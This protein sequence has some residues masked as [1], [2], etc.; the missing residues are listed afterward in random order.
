MLRP[1][2]ALTA[3]VLLAAALGCRETK[4]QPEPPHPARVHAPDP[5]DP[6]LSD[7]LL[8]HVLR[9]ADEKLAGRPTWGPEAHLAR[10]YIQ[11]Q[12]AQAGFAPTERL[13]PRAGKQVVLQR[14]EVPIERLAAGNFLRIKF[15]EDRAT[16]IHIGKLGQTFLP[17]NL[18]VTAQIESSV[19]FAG[20]GVRA[21]EVQIDDYREQPV[22]RKVVFVLD[23]LPA[24]LR[25][26]R[27]AATAGPL[28][29]GTVPL[30]DP[31]GEAAAKATLARSLGAAGL[32]LIVPDP[33]P[34]QGADG[35][36]DGEAGFLECTAAAWDEFL[37]ARQRAKVESLE[38]R[39]GNYTPLLA[40]VGL[41]SRQ[42]RPDAS[43]NL[44]AA[45]IPVS[46]AARVLGLPA[47]RLTEAL[48]SGIAPGPISLPRHELL[49]NTAIELRRESGQNIV[50][51]LPG[52]DPRLR[53]EVVVVGAHYDHLGRDAS[54]H[55]FPGAIDNATGVGVLIEA[56]RALSASFP[57]PKRSI[58]FVAF[59]G[60]EWGLWGSRAFAQHPPVPRERI[61]AM[62]NVD[63]AGFAQ[64]EQCTVLG[65]LRNPEF[66]ALA[67]AANAGPKLRF[68]TDIEFAYKF[69]SDHWPFHEAGIP[70]LMISTSRFPEYHTRLDLPDLVS[71]E[72]MDAMM[73]LL[74]DLTR[75]LASSADR[76]P[77]P[78]QFDVPYP[79]H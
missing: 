49:L 42:V 47:E 78:R 55:H 77:A 51:F 19:L 4:I 5:P 26:P 70:A 21:D 65:G 33:A 3:L 57:K 58:C 74:T 34:P 20:F 17:L 48:R 23:G 13:D 54:D 64:N 2:A 30:P 40:A 68:K 8:R 11:E 41:Q 67:V 22:E 63:M 60:E 18:A 16:T 31:R 59:A 9:L 46:L 71:R 53:D 27:R 6:R 37:P 75:E 38:G 72:M 36:P 50:A 79:R 24:A 61:V 62:L 10:E 15:V 66:L 7:P 12:F 25:A 73:R 14:F 32:V 29:A 56:A 45:C 43:F 35:K 39:N 1:V 69:G 44:P 28:P 52:E 76:L